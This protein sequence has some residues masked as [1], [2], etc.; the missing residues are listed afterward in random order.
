MILNEYIRKMSYILDFIKSF[1]D[2]NDVNE[3]IE[4]RSNNKYFDLSKSIKEN[5]STI[6][7]YI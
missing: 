7:G 1:E 3:F 4:K 6:K 5:K 2:F